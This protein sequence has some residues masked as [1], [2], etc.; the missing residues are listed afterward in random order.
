MIAT[1]RNKAFWIMKQYLLDIKLSESRANATAHSIVRYKNENQ[2]NE[3][4]NEYNA[5]EGK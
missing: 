3:I 4:I 2:L 5:K 1:L